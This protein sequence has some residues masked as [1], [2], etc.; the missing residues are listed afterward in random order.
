MNN[1]KHWLRSTGL[2]AQ[3]LQLSEQ[4][5]ATP[6]LRWMIWAVVYIVLLY[7]ALLLQN[8][9]ASISEQ[10]Y[11]VERSFTSMQ[12]LQAQTQWSSRLQAEAALA[13]QLRKKYWRAASKGLAEADFQKHIKQLFAQ[14]ATER[15]RIKMAPTETEGEL[16]VVKLEASGALD[17][18]RVDELMAKLASSDRYIAVE[19]FNYSP[20]RGGQASFILAG[21]FLSGAP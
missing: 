1:F 18:E 14:L 5:Q 12:N 13:E 9:S 7:L 3:W 10:V 15:L 4:W 6:R 16:W 2:D 11:R 17:T 21:Y 20:Q 19:R 8:W